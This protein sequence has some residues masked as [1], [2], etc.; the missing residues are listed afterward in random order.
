MNYPRAVL[1][2][3]AV[4]SVGY[5]IYNFTVLNAI[6]SFASIIRRLFLLL[7]WPLVL[8]VNTR[9]YEKVSCHRTGGVNKSNIMD[10]QWLHNRIYDGYLHSREVNSPL[11]SY[12]LSSGS[13]CVKHPFL[14]M[15]RYPNIIAGSALIFP[16]PHRD[17]GYSG[18]FNV[19]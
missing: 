1:I 13:T 14:N 8:L 6:P 10:I 12:V 15:Y 4:R 7:A 3:D 19:V 2:P 9:P 5:V 17:T 18:I 11:N 16:A